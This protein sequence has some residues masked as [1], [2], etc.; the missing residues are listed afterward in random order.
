MYMPVYTRRCL[1]LPAYTW[2]G[3][4]VVMWN[5]TQVAV[6]SSWPLSSKSDV[7]GYE[8]RMANPRSAEPVRASEGE[9]VDIGC[10]GIAVSIKWIR[11]A[12]LDRLLNGTPIQGAA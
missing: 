5:W 8:T 12:A 6:V 10:W 11:V 1:Y 9:M 7:S 2:R 3:L 4:S